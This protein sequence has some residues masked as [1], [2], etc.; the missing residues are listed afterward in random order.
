MVSSN[1]M[2]AMV[3]VLLVT[4]LVPLVLA[5]ALY[6]YQRY[7][8]SFLFIGA[9]IFFISQV[10]LRLP[11]LALLDMSPWH[12]SMLDSVVYATIIF[13]FTAGIFE[14]SG[15]WIAFRLTRKKE[16]RWSDAVAFGIGHGGLEAVLLVGLTQVSNLIISVMINSGAFE[17]QIAPTLG[18]EAE[19]LRETM[20]DLTSDILILGAIERLAVF[21]IH[22]FFSI[23]VCLAVIKKK[24]ILLLAAVILHGIVNA[25]AVVGMMQGWN[26]YIIEGIVIVFG[27]L[28][29]WGSIYLKKFFSTKVEMTQKE[30]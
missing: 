4:I 17:A 10:I 16:P 18:A 20:V 24:P 19:Q 28:A 30:A 29:L 27:G 11:F 15:R 25:P 1:V 2:I 8:V 22:I 12:V 14:E 21:P 13:A 9:L 23:L 26:I 3:F 7:R 5:I 6:R